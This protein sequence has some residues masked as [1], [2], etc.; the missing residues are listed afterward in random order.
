MTASEK[1]WQ[2]AERRA[3]SPENMLELLALVIDRAT[4]AQVSKINQEI[5][6]SVYGW[7]KHIPSWRRANEY[8]RILHDYEIVSSDLK[9][10]TELGQPTDYEKLLREYVE[11]KLHLHALRK[12]MYYPFDAYA[13]RE[14]DF[15]DVLQRC[16]EL[17]QTIKTIR[18]GQS[19]AAWGG[20]EPAPKPTAYDKPLLYAM[21]EHTCSFWDVSVDPDGA[22]C[23]LSAEHWFR[24]LPY[25]RTHFVESRQAAKLTKRY[26]SQRAR[27]RHAAMNM[28]GSHAIGPPEK[29]EPCGY[30]GTCW[31]T[32]PHIHAYGGVKYVGEVSALEPS[33]LIRK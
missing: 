14:G 13:E 29:G 12:T 21:E 27:A 32:Q 15:K 7:R 26:Q 10:K 11:L 9:R 8:D 22:A 2:E 17:K 4:S 24:G 30:D 5:G 1:L 18:R 31:R 33:F 28:S 6:T 3:N 16:E 23:P 20:L 25:C 19:T